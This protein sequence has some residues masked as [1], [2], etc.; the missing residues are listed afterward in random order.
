MATNKRARQRAN[1]AEKMAQEAKVSRRA[2]MLKRVRRVVIYAVII[3]L[4][5]LL[6]NQV[7]G[8]DGDELALAALLGA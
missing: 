5:I 7:F 3:A 1:R 6:A 2:A 8:G 4:V